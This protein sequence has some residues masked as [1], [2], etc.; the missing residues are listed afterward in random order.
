MNIPEGILRNW[1][2]GRQYIPHRERERLAHLPGCS[3][4]E[5]VSLPDVD[6]PAPSS[7]YAMGYLHEM[8]T[9]LSL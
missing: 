1:A 6:V 9:V 3:M 8:L 4:Q 5:L 7:H 2:G